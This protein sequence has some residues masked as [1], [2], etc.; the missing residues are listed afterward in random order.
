MYSKYSIP[1]RYYIVKILI[2]KSCERR[3]PLFE[4]GPPSNYIS[5]A[6][7]HLKNF[8]DKNLLKFLLSVKLYRPKGQPSKFDQLLNQ[9]MHL[10][11]GGGGRLVGD[12]YSSFSHSKIDLPLS[13]GQDFHVPMALYSGAIS[14]T[15]CLLY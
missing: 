7:A 11:K 5:A 14:S 12:Q 6:A 1:I 15:F 10:S 4:F 8:R 9:A 13:D 2:R 3:C